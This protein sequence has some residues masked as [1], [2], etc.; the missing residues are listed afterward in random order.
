MTFG[1]LT[2][3][4]PPP[5]EEA[6]GPMLRQAHKVWI[7]ETRRFLLPATLD[8]ASFWDRWTAVRYLA[9]QFQGQYRRERALLNELRPFLTHGRV[10]RLCRDGDRIE[11]IRLGLDNLG[12]RRGTALKVASASR[13]L[14]ELLAR[15]CSEI[16]MAASRLP[17]SVLTPEATR[18]VVEERP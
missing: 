2:T 16:E 15:W 7:R 14:L 11:Q 9:D 10:E 1:N 5:P 13:E 17:T 4:E 12:R 6:L 3:H 18:L 8:T